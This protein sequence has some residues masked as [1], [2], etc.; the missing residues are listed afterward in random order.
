MT[1]NIEMDK[2]YCYR[3]VDGND[4]EGRPVI[5]LFRRVI[6]RETE[7]TFWHVYDMPYMPLET[8]IKYQTGGPK[9]N[10]K[11]NV[12]RCAK[13]A[14]RSSYHY[15]KEEALRAFVYRK[16]FQLEKMQLREET[17]RLCLKGLRDGGF[18]T[19]GFQCTVEKLPD[20]REFLAAQEKG[21]VA[22]TYN[23]GDY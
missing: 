14:Y 3:Y 11:R 18:I 5:S 13:G 6:I 19:G 2:K 17:V 12:K 9:E 4:S 10:V 23:W 16:M 22:S 20:G 7:K 1:N 15:T 21:P 8:L